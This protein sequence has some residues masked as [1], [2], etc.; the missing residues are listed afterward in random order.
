MPSA[1]G[2][3]KLRIGRSASSDIVIADN[4]VSRNHAEIAMYPDGRI[5]LRDT[6]ST[7]GTYVIDLDGSPKR[8]N[9]SWITF[10][11]TVKFGKVQIKISDL[12]A[13]YDIP[14]TE[15]A[16]CG[17]FQ[18]ESWNPRE[19]ILNRGNKPDYSGAGL[20]APARNSTV[21]VKYPL[22]IIIALIAL[23]LS[24]TNPSMDDFIAYSK[25]IASREVSLECEDDSP[26]ALFLGLFA[27]E[28]G[29]EIL[30]ENTRRSNFILFSRYTGFMPQYGDFTVIG[31]FNSFI[32]TQDPRKPKSGDRRCPPGNQSNPFRSAEP[33]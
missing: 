29:A 2:C 21:A 24:F 31:V 9:E 25:Q 4:T 7:Q 6:A 5:F 8:I 26:I 12:L 16:G 17:R 23:L 28:I 33:G 15:T 32:I 13:G 3:I 10:R 14:E 20:R 19:S 22:G 30:T 18:E 27:G 11:T 1:D